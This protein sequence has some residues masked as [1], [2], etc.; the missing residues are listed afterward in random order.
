MTFVSLAAETPAEA[1]GSAEFV[2]ILVLSILLG[3]LIITLVFGRGR[4]HA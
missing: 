4:P 1:S 2:G 3:L